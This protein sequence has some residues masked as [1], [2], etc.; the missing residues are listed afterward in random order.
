MEYETRE[1]T[2]GIGGDYLTKDHFTLTKEDV[3][4]KGEAK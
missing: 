3:F 4:G 2:A 1:M